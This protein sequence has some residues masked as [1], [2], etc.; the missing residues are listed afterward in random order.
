MTVSDC[1]CVMHNV[2][3]FNLLLLGLCFE[4]VLV[5]QMLKT[6]RLIFFSF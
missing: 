5:M 1:M 4:D 2:N 6:P 3:M